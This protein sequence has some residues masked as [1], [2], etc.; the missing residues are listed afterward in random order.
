MAGADQSR[1]TEPRS[2]RELRAERSWA[3][4]HRE[5]ARRSSGAAVA[6]RR[7]TPVGCC[8]DRWPTARSSLQRIS[9]MQTQAQLTAAWRHELLS[10][11]DV[12]INMTSAGLSAFPIEALE[13]RQSRAKQLVTS[14]IFFKTAKQNARNK[15]SKLKRENLNNVKALEKLWQQNLLKK[16]EDLNN[17]KKQN[18]TCEWELQHD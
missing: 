8:D 1:R 12:R 2:T 18:K 6:R 10:V 4:S 13:C 7:A 5:I 17:S 16:E 3:T 9:L 11:C 15:I 14:L